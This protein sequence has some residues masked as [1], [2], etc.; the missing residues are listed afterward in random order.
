MAAQQK[1]TSFADV[2]MAHFDEHRPNN[3]FDLIEKFKQHLHL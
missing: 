3:M 2:Q 1:K